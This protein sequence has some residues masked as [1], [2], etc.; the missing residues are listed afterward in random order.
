MEMFAR[1]LSFP[2]EKYLTSY[3]ISQNYLI[4]PV[5]T[6]VHQVIST[7]GS[8]PGS[9]AQGPEVETARELLGLDKALQV[10]LRQIGGGTRLW[11]NPES[12]VH[13][14]LPPT[15]SFRSATEHLQRQGSGK[16]DSVPQS[17][18]D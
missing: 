8:V 13:T 1:G 17:G 3:C 12:F 7:E 14:N 15:T 4:D 18:T 5:T 2:A 10:L 9:E 6:K 11:L 16:P